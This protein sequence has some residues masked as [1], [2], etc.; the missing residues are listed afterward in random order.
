M[1]LRNTKHTA[2]HLFSDF[3]L[4]LLLFVPYSSIV[5]DSIIF[6]L[7]LLKLFS[8]LFKSISCT[9]IFC[10][11]V[12]KTFNS[13]LFPLFKDLFKFLLLSFSV[14]TTHNLVHMKSGNIIPCLFGATALPKWVLSLANMLIWLLLAS[15]PTTFLVLICN[16]ILSKFHV[17]IIISLLDF[18]IINSFLIIL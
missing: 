16:F 7:Y 6:V 3:L 17:F 5:V 15:S 11:I 4:P 1:I 13:T 2:L 10:V 14:G 12:K 9:C 8:L 18:C